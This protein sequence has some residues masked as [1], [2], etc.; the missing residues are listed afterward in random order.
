MEFDPSAINTMMDNW[1]NIEDEPGILDCEV[2]EVIE[3]SLNN[4][5]DDESDSEEGETESRAPLPKH[6][7]PQAMIRSLLTVSHAVQNNIPED[8]S[9]GLQKYSKELEKRAPRTRSIFSERRQVSLQRNLS[10][11]KLF[12]VPC[13]CIEIIHVFSNYVI[14]FRL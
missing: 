14:V 6:Q 5:S 3:R 9:Q 2:D 10:T 8:I 11:S 1:V 4:E 12:C 7:E 13:M